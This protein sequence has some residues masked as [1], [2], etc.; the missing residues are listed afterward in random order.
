MM[1]ISK[2][3]ESR[4]TDD[5]RVFISNVKYGIS[6]ATEDKNELIELHNIVLGGVIYNMSLDSSIKYTKEYIKLSEALLKES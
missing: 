2:N 5:D 4:L 1:N 3:L 6:T